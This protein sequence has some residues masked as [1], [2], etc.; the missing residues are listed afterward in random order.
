MTIEEK[1]IIIM[2]ILWIFVIGVMVSQYFNNPIPLLVFW[3]GM[4]L[5]QEA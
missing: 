1:G 2:R 5:F 3:F 4:Y